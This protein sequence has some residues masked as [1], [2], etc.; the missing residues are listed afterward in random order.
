ML[1]LK[2][3]L[4]KKVAVLSVEKKDRM[5]KLQELHD[6]ELVL[7]KKL[8]VPGKILVI[9]SVPTLKQLEDFRQ[10]VRNLESELV[11]IFQSFFVWTLTLS[12]K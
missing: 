11:R 2:E 12:Q 9:G 1:Q 5:G 7:C 4:S 6:N 3:V 8:N 10:Q